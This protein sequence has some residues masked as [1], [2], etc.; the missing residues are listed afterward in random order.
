MRFS[1]LPVLFL[2]HGSPMNIINDN[3]YTRMLR[4]Y[5]KSIPT[6]KAVV[7]VSAHWQTRG[8]FVTGADNPEQIYDFY[9]FPKTLYD[10]EY[11]PPGFLH[12]QSRFIG[13][14]RPLLLIGI[15][16]SIMRAGC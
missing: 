11:R 16:V 1:S 14:F 15:V 7:I 12:L 8:T 3:S 9:G 6:P 2:G 10:I 5:S 13:S 4:A